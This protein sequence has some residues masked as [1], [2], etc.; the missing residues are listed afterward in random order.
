MRALTRFRTSAI[1]IATILAMLLVPACGSFCASMNHCST[2]DASANADSC[3]HGDMSVSHDS[4]AQSLSSQPSCGQQASSGA[5]LAAPESHFQLQSVEAAVSSISLAS[6][7]NALDS[8]R[9][10]FFVSN[11]SPRSSPLENLSILRI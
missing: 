9:F 3:H 10:E 4:A 2:S 11:E 1:A 7:A 8:H 5:T 6:G